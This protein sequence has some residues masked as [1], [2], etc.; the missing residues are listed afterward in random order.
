M[1]SITLKHI[2]YLWKLHELKSS[3]ELQKQ[4][5]PE[6]LKKVINIISDCPY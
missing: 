4:N 1:H 3:E 6:I 5:R 2:A